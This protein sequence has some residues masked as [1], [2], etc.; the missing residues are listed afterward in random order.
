MSSQTSPP[1]DRDRPA[2][3]RPWTSKDPIYD[4]H[5]ANIQP[6]HRTN[7]VHPVH[8]VLRGRTHASEPVVRTTPV[9]NLLYSD[10][11]GLRPATDTSTNAQR[12]V[13]I[14][15]I[16]AHRQRGQQPTR[17]Q[18][19]T[20]L[21]SRRTLSHRARPS[22]HRVRNMGGIIRRRPSELC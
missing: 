11:A 6:V 13:L 20:Q 8:V 19:D 1:A 9:P 12:C 4:S 2:P 15:Q 22:L 16:Q 3:S 21:V 18:P 10:H 7:R 17:G 14:D 5:I